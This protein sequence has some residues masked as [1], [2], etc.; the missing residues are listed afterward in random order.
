MRTR[1]FGPALEAGPAGAAP[2]EEFPG[3]ASPESHKR[4][5]TTAGLLSLFVHLGIFGLLLL[6]AWLAPPEIIE[7]F[8]P[9]EL[10][11]EPVPDSEPAPA[12]RAI[13]ETRGAFAPAAQA[14]PAQIITPSVIARAA[15]VA[16]A[17]TLDMAAVSNVAA[18][19]DVTRA[20]VEA[21]HVSAVRSVAAASTSPIAVA[22]VAPAL[23]GPIGV[24]APVGPSVGPRQVVKRGDTVGLAAPGAL[25]TG[26][27]VREGI[28]SDRDVAGS[29]TG[30]RLASVNTRVG[31]G[32]M[33]GGTGGQGTGLG[34][35]FEECSNRPEVVAY[36][37]QIRERVLSRWVIPPGVAANQ[38]VTLRFKLDAAGSATRVNLVSAQD[39]KRGQ[40]AVE[41]LRSA[42]PFPAMS[43]RVRC[44]AHDRI[45]ATFRNPTSGAS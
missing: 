13:A 4:S 21:Q 2:P 33:G 11:N 5:N 27:S 26:S 22:P 23:R 20:N 41:A 43:D 12:P 7:E 19:R 45:N 29:P 24:K 14:V 28:A 44:L 35:T 18:P 1:R 17:E 15:P 10:V 32:M 30:P 3:L 25:G 38:E 37:D 16:P 6:F 42:S 39:P 36:M 34:V 40:S 9:V 31:T 8:L